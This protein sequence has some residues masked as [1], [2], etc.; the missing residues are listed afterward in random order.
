MTLREQIEAFCP[1]CEQEQSDRRLILRYMDTFSDLLTRQNEMAHFTASCWIVNREQTKV[2]MAFH[3]LY[4]SWAWLGGHADGEEELL[5]V[6][7]RE[8]A[9]E[10]GIAQARPLSEQIFS[11]EI[12]GVDAHRKRGRHVSTH[13]HLNATFLLCAD[14]ALPIRAR[15]E[16]NSAVRWIET[17]RV[18]SEVSEPEMRVVYQKLIDRAKEYR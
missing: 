4:Q 11:L 5:R 13:L 1:S 16:E 10:S 7:M 14:D 9:E 6:A 2:L 17:E 3:N 12:L 15:P 18:L 8:A